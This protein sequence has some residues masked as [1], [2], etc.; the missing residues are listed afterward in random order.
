MQYNTIVLELIQQ[1]P[2]LHDQLTSSNSLLSAVNH[3]APL[4]RDNHLAIIEE[5]RE[6]RPESAEIQLASEAIELALEQLEAILPPEEMKNETE[7]LTL[8]AAMAYLRKQTPGG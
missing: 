1:R 8:D 5:L 7:T 4:L 6:K 2:L 3:Y